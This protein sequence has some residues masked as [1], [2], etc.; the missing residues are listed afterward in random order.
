PIKRLS[1]Q[2]RQSTFASC[3]AEVRFQL[4]KGPIAIIKQI[5]PISGKKKKLKYGGPT[6]IFPQPKASA[7]KGY[8]VPSRTVIMTTTSRILLLSK[9]VSRDN[10]LKLGILLTTGARKA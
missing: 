8:K 1:T 4:D 2:G 9:R 6:E 5:T 7:I 10:Q 3:R